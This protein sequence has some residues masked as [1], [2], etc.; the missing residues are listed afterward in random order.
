[1]VWVLQ[2]R[3]RLNKMIATAPSQPQTSQPRRSKLAIFASVR[4]TVALLAFIA[5]TVLL[6]A[7][8]PQESQVGQDKVVE[9]FGPEMAL[10]LHNLGITDIFHTPW[11]LIL[12]GLLTVNMV[13]CS[14]QRVFP[15]VRSLKLPMPYLGGEAIEKLPLVEK[16]ALGAA[17]PRALDML[18]QRLIACRYKVRRNGN[19]LVAEFGKFGRLA[20]TITHIGLLTLLAGVT[21]TS[22]TGFSGFQPIPVGGSLDFGS[23]EHSRLWIGKLPEWRVRVDASR[24]EDYESGDPKQWYSDLTVIDGGLPVKS[25]QISVNNPLSYKG[26][27]IYQSSWDLD[28]IVLRFNGR[29]RRFELRQMGKVHA[30]FLPLEAETVLIFSIRNQQQPLRIF[31]KTPQ[32][33][34]PRLLTEIA[35]GKSARLGSVELTYV[36]VIP[37][38][39]LQY[40]CDPGLPITY[41]AFGF[42]ITGVLLAAVPHRQVWAYAEETGSTSNL[43]PNGNGTA[44]GRVDLV[45]VAPG[46]S[47]LTT[48][49]TVAGSTGPTPL[50]AGEPEPTNLGA[51]LEPVERLPSASAPTSIAALAPIHGQLDEN[52]TSTPAIGCTLLVGGRSLK[53]RTAFEK[54]LRKIVE[55]MKAEAGE[56]A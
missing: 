42:I 1:M 6:G 23:S 34:A 48:I 27:D 21:I 14:M 55:S 32:W 44:D 25:Q 16:V 50:A 46:Q 51:M 31:A 7:W 13:A 53:A 37:V 47:E 22:W 9:Q 30:A 43:G 39:G 5:T 11:F 41:I 3:S 2:A 54:D 19:A 49:A 12:I 4:M 15:K 36:S 40:K 28:S 10:V 52:P 45:P 18:E 38:T 33:E 20:P 17:P 29:E 35:A 26:V 8:C 24:R 56:L